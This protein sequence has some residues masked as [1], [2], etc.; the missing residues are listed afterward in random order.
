MVV[1]FPC[2][3]SVDINPLL[4]DADGVVALD[5]RIEIDPEKVDEPGPNPS[6]AIR[7]YPAEWEREIAMAD[8]VYRIR[9]IKP[10]DVA[11]Y[12]A[13]L[14]KVSA[15]DIRLRFLAPRRAFPDEM[16]RRLTQLDYDRDMAFVLLREAD[17]ALA[18]VGRL[19]RDPDRSKAE[20]AL[21]VRTDLQGKGLGWLLLQ[22]IVAYARAEKIGRVEGL[23]LEENAAMLKMCREFGFSVAPHPDEP[24]V[25][26]VSL[27]LG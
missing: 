2:L 24:G 10:A 5:A 11:L 15:N 26:V 21:L 7:P 9:P 27:D 18:A 3:V 6:L 1:D 8:E 12:P 17:G 25:A 13:F 16:L 20:Y 23:V 14:A 19:S 22:E 4:A